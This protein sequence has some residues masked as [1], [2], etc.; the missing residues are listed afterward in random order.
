MIPKQWYVVLD[1]TQVGRNPVGVKRMGEKLVFWRDEAGILGCL[2][3]RRVVQTQRP[4]PSGL[5]IGEKLIQG[6]G[7]IIEYRKR[8]RELKQQTGASTAQ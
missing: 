3:D 6:D 2:H 1:S 7:P 8:R 5:T 4:R